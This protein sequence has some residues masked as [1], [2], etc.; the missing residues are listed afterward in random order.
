VSAP[1]NQ[2]VTVATS[3]NVTRPG[4]YSSAGTSDGRRLI[5]IRITAE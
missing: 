3:G 2:W 4:S 1:L 5:Q